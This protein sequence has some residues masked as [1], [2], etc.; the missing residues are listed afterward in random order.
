MAEG[1]FR[2]SRTFLAIM[3]GVLGI[4][5]VGYLWGFQTAM[6][7]E[8]RHQ[9]KRFPQLNMRPQSLPPVAANNSPGATLA[10][11]GLGI[12]VPW[13]DLDAKK[14]KYSKSLAVFAFHSGKVVSLYGPSPSGEDLLSSVEKSFGD[15]QGK[16]IEVFGP[17]VKPWMDHREAERMSTLLTI[18]ALSPVGGATG[19]FEV[20]ANGWRGFQFDDPA[21]KPRLVT[22]ELYDPQDRRVEIIFASKSGATER[23]TQADINRVIQTLKPSTEVVSAQTNLSANSMAAN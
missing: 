6:S 14:S 13:E 9:A 4:L 2:M 7:F 22:L 11:A 19:I 17:S 8:L 15:D 3:G 21:K 5:V 18:K 1:R 10:H 20:A 12:E 16:V 23:I